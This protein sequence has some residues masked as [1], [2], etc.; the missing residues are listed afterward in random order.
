MGRP[1]LS[2]WDCLPGKAGGSPGYTRFENG[3][4]SRA[5]YLASLV[6]EFDA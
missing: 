6:G 2:N 5:A 3:H 1:E 4:Y